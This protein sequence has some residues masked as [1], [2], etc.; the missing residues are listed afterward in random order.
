VE[1][2]LTAKNLV[3][4]VSLLVADA[5]L[6]PQSHAETFV[7]NSA[8]VRLQLDFQVANGD[9]KNALPIGWETDVAT[10]GGAKDCNLRMIFV[11]RV[12]I[13]GPDDAD[14]GTSQFV[15]LEVPVNKPGTGLVRRRV[16][17]G[18]TANPE[19]APGPFKVYRPAAT[20]RM[21]RTT[22]A[23]SGQPPQIVEDWDFTGAD[24]A[25]MALH[26]K[27]ERGTPRKGGRAHGCL[28]RQAWTRGKELG[29]LTRLDDQARNLEQWVSGP[30]VE[31]L[32]S[33]EME[34]SRA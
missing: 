23:K 26:L 9:I 16:I 21:E 2:F 3:S 15:Y 25:R 24:G 11:D 4:V 12:A 29:V 1:E 22:S 30:R 5:L 33:H 18:L 7:E 19:D 10:L 32:I 17:D 6:P 14:Q 34:N 20:Y 31:E 13:T 28:Q 27:C 8:E